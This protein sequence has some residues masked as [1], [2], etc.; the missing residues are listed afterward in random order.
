MVKLFTEAHNRI[1]DLN[2]LKI[3]V[4]V[5]SFYVHFSSSFMYNSVV[6]TCRM[7]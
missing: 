6:S 2:N 4:E 1:L 3:I 5:Y 7:T